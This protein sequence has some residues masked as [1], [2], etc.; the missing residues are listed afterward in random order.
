MAKATVIPLGRIRL[1]ST[2]ECSADNFSTWLGDI[3]KVSLTAGELINLIAIIEKYPNI[4]VTEED[5]D[6]IVKRCRK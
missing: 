3:Y 5:L 6:T 4:Q 2:F 1:D